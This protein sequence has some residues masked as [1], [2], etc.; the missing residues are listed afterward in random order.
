MNQSLDN[1]HSSKW[2][3]CFV[4]LISKYQHL[5]DLLSSHIP[6]FRSRIIK[7]EDCLQKHLSLLAAI[8][9]MVSS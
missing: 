2:L 5:L 7:V 3:Q 1:S 4:F 6:T 8:G 9:K